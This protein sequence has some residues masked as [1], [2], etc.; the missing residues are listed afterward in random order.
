MALLQNIPM[1]EADGIGFLA[2]C[3]LFICLFML[4]LMLS[5]ALK[6]VPEY[7]RVAVFRLGR[8]LG[9]RG[10]GT[11]IAI[12][13]VDRLAAIDLREQERTYQGLP[14]LTRDNQ[15]IVIDLLAR[16][17][18][19]KLEQYVLNVTNLETSM[20]ELVRSTL[21]DV[22]GGM[23]YAD[24]VTQRPQLVQDVLGRAGETAGRW[25]A[26]ILGLELRDIRREQA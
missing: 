2:V 18:V 19:V 17:R 5:L 21:S 20:Q 23:D 25:G 12:P 4:M 13:F 16:Y 14:V 24:I 26:E 9:I 7:Q 15:R 22:A 1:Q 10:P 11:I 8:F 3:M 6:I